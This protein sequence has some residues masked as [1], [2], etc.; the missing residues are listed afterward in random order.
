[1]TKFYCIFIVERAAPILGSRRDSDG[2]AVYPDAIGGIPSE[3]AQAC[4][5][6]YRGYP[7]KDGVHLPVRTQVKNYCF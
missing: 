1:M 4:P 7:D 6:D 3:M 5:D 2:I